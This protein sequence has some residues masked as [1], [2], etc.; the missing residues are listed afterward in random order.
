M[1]WFYAVNGEKTGPLDEAKMKELVSSG[2]INADTLVWT[3]GMPEWKKASESTLFSEGNIPPLP[4]KL[5]SG[6]AVTS[7]VLGI[8]SIV[9]CLGPLTA[10]PGLI[11]GIIALV[12]IGKRKASGMGFAVTGIVTSAIGVFLIGVIAIFASIMLPALNQAREKA[13]RIQCMN[14]MKQIGLALK[15][16]AIDYEDQLPPFDG[17]KGLEILRAND[18]LSDPKCFICPSTNTISAAP[19]KPLTEENISYV[20]KGGLIDEGKYEEMPVLWDKDDNH[21]NYGN[22]L[23]VDGHVQGIP[24]PNWK[25]KLKEPVKPVK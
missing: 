1:N 3:E 10:I 8:V 13:K 15:N 16:Y 21:R 7:M 18:Y 24:G 5:G 23:Y 25:D 9:L 4:E 22:I 6:L 11:I 17:A 14:N 19:G 20:Y 12:R 2:V